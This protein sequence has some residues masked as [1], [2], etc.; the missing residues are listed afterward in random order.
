MRGGIPFIA[1]RHS[2]VNS[3]HMEYYDS[4]KKRKYIAYLDPNS[5]YGWAM[6]QPLPYCRFK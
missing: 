6:G 3:K 5:L 4:S 1:K 2:K